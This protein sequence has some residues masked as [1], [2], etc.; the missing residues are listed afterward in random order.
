MAIPPEQQ[1]E[2]QL[3]RP[4]LRQRK[5]PRGTTTHDETHANEGIDVYAIYYQDRERSDEE[6]LIE[7]REG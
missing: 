4:K 1:D 2:E 3:I 5:A 7:A 6:E